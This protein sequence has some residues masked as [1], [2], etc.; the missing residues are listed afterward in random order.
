M[1]FSE[2]EI[3]IEGSTLA[4]HTGYRC[5]HTAAF[6]LFFSQARARTQLI[7]ASESAI[8]QRRLVKGWMEP[9]SLQ[10]ELLDFP[11]V[12]Q[13]GWVA[14][15]AALFRWAEFLPE[16]LENISRFF[17]GL[18]FDVL[19]WIRVTGSGG[20]LEQSKAISIT[21]MAAILKSV[22]VQ[23]SLTCQENML[24]VDLL[25]RRE[26]VKKDDT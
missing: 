4:L 11:A 17:L 2:Q 18:S 1:A 8:H 10:S 19:Q 22:M 6:P 9:S 24:T 5:R 12:S 3:D 14:V 16:P 23:V 7:T 15:K 21:H 25:T 13:S 20:L 26:E